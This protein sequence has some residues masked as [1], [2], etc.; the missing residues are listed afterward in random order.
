[1]LFFFFIITVNYIYMLYLLSLKLKES[2]LFYMIYSILFY[3]EVQLKENIFINILFIFI[4][5]LFIL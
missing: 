5:I 4:N 1:M 3:F 2:L